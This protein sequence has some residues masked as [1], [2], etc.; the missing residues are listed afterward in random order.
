MEAKIVYNKTDG[1]GTRDL[2]ILLEEPYKGYHDYL[3][4][5][6]GLEFWS[7]GHHTEMWEYSFQAGEKRFQY[8]E[9]TETWDEQLSEADCLA[10]A[11]DWY[12]R[13]RQVDKP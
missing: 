7:S 6:L 1:E 3:W 10:A 12:D 9:P 4:G 11:R 13:R 8:Q 5:G 2:E